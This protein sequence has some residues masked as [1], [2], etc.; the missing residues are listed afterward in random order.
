MNV[1]V[2]KQIKIL[3]VNEDES[4]SSLAAKLGTSSQN[5]SAKLKRNN[6]SINEMK[7]IAEALGYDLNIEFVKRD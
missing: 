2:S 7:E 3:L 1:N 5:I 4:I 6:F